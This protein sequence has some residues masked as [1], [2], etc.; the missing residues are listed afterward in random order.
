MDKIKSL[1]KKPI[2]GELK[3]EDKFLFY[4]YRY[5]LTSDPQ[6]LIYFLSSINWQNP[7]ESKEAL[8]LMKKWT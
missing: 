7:K 1:V 6:A 2:I 3:N 5:F 8:N 4:K